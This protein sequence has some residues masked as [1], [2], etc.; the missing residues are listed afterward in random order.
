MSSRVLASVLTIAISLMLTA[1]YS[2]HAAKPE[3]ANRSPIDSGQLLQMLSLGRSKL[4]ARLYQ[5]AWDHFRKMIRQNAGRLAADKEWAYFTPVEFHLWKE[6]AAV[7]AAAERA[8]VSLQA[9]E[10]PRA[11]ENLSA[12]IRAV[13]S[14]PLSDAEKENLERELAAILPAAEGCSLAILTARLYAEEPGTTLA[15]ISHLERAKR[16]CTDRDERWVITGLLAQLRGQLAQNVEKHRL[17][18]ELEKHEY[19]TQLRDKSAIEQLQRLRGSTADPT[20]RGD[21][22]VKLVGPQP[23]IVIS[24]RGKVLRRTVLPASWH[25]SRAWGQQVFEIG[26]RIYVL[27][28][29]LTEAQKTEENPLYFPGMTYVLDRDGAFVGAHDA[30]E[31]TKW[32]LVDIASKRYKLDQSEDQK[33]AA[34]IGFRNS[35]YLHVL[36]SFAADHEPS[37]YL[38]ELVAIL[39]AINLDNWQIAV[40]TMRRVPIAILAERRTELV[41]AALKSN[42]IPVTR[43]IRGIMRDMLR[44]LER[45][46]SGEALR[47]QLLAFSE[48]F[49]EKLWSV[50]TSQ[51]VLERPS[52]STDYEFAIGTLNAM[53]GLDP[54]RFARVRTL[55]EDH[56][57][58]IHRQNEARDAIFEAGARS[59]DYLDLALALPATDDF[60]SSHRLRVVSEIILEQSEEDLEK[61][62][63][64]KTIA[65]EL[66]EFVNTLIGSENP[67]LLDSD[68]LQAQ[69]ALEKGDPDYFE[70]LSGKRDFFLEPGRIH[71]DGVVDA[72]K[73]IAK[74][75]G[76][77]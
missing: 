6:M 11:V 3:P 34:R 24:R 72:F 48:P 30:N 68:H 61:F 41:S 16:Y 35:L 45:N 40:K 69:Y 71:G 57:N 43:A 13:T 54:V 62:P 26:N 38:N 67:G 21:L 20:E 25:P 10:D 28:S 4:E 52:G 64:R 65:K 37:E 75:L 46:H 27:T 55:I 5:G 59:L 9:H 36:D 7:R 49:E 2:L 76:I 51:S 47:D 56:L 33:E 66:R 63:R 53:Y 32:N 42:S 60:S 44:D 8:K 70:W 74:K 73:E 18:G 17:I 31:Q 58:N 29:A 15:A 1:S 39:G 77:R 14:R 19:V 22:R 23:Q 50:V 12:D